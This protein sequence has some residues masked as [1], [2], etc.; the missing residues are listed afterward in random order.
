MDSS[1][2]NARLIFGEGLFQDE[3][4]PSA[5][6]FDEMEST[7]KLNGNEWRTLHQVLPNYSLIHFQ[8]YQ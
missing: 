2:D 4:I 3:S 8:T 5:R 7:I 1:H 6:A